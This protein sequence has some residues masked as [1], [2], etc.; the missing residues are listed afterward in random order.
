MARSSEKKKKAS[1]V[2][3]ASIPRHAPQEKPANK[4]EGIK[5]ADY[6]RCKKEGVVSTHVEWKNILDA[7][8]VI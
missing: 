1:R 5:N 2:V 3:P 8:R 4:F 7:A 6:T